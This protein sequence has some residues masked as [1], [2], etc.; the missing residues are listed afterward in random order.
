MKTLV[1]NA[2]DLRNNATDTEKFLWRHL[3]LRQL[4]GFK[5]RRQVPIGKYIVDFACLEKRVVIECDGGQHADQTLKDTDRDEWLTEEGYKVLRFW[6]TDVLQNTA[7]VLK[8]ILDECGDHP[9]SD[10]LPS[11][12][13]EKRQPMRSTRTQRG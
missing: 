8:I 2:K 9:P 1:S 12:E 6:N 3:K 11:R 5:F 7:G 13:G 10:S 4:A